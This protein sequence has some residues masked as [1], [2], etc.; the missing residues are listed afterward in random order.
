M[1]LI[2]YPIM[3]ENRVPQVIMEWFFMM[4]CIELSIVFF[5]RYIRQDKELRNLQDLGYSL[6]LFCFGLMEL[7]FIIGDYYAPNY[8]IRII[9]LILGYSSTFIGAFS[10]IFCNEK[11]K[12]F[13]ISRYFFSIA[14][15]II[16]IIFIIGLFIDLETSR[17]L[18]ILPW[19]LFLFFFLIY[20]IDFSKRVQNR[21]KVI[22]GLLKFIPGFTMLIIGFALTTDTFERL[23]G[24]NLRLYGVIA[25]LISILF[26]SYF[27]IS[28]PPFAE[29]EWERQMEH[30]FVMN[31]GGVCLY[32]QI[33]KQQGDLIDEDLVSGAITSVNLLLEELI[34]D[35]GVVVI[36]KKGKTIIIYPGEKTYGVMFCSEEL[37]YIK[38][39]LKRF[40]ERFEA[41]YN[42]ILIDW[43]GDIDTFNPTNILVNEI[44][45]QE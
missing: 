14:F 11:Y 25:E 30:I 6:L 20:L 28:L 10:F 41:V 17:T 37:N 45:H 23:L 38:V 31:K 1:F 33:F 22:V 40:V 9:F 39:L 24:I 43:D 16:I 4:A 18:S 27:F 36:N 35:A 21:E 7:W 15:L 44:F 2:E 26:L 12:K 32:N 29:F 3:G 19:P 34:S 13:I 42:N 8:S 5:Q